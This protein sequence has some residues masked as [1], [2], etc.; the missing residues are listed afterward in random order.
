MSDK[1]ENKPSF[2]EGVKAEFNKI[3]WPEVGVIVKQS[4]AVICTSVVVGIII[5]AVDALVKYGVSFL[6]K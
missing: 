1:P 4:V 6:A 2:W 5:S 3:T